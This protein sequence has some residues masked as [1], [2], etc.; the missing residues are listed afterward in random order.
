M[1]KTIRVYFAEVA[2]HAVVLSSEETRSY[3]RQLSLDRGVYMASTRHDYLM[4]R[5]W[6]VAS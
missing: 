6:E 2:R 4:L 1:E 5:P 3:V